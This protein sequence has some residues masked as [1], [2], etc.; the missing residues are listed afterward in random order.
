V[1]VDAIVLNVA[2]ELDA[3]QDHGDA[4]DSRAIPTSHQRWS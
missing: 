3:G 1:N 2:D 4:H